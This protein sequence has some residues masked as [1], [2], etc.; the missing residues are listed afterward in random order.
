[1]YRVM[2]VDDELEIRSGLKL[3][4]DWSALGYAIEGEAQ[5]GREALALLEREPFDLVLTDIRMPVMS[6]LELLKQC[7]EN[8]P[9]TKVIVLSGY[10]DFHFVKAALQCGAK[11]YLLKPVV[12]SE[13]TAILGK[14]SGELETER[15][16][17]FSDE[18]ARQR[19]TESESVLKEQLVLDWI[20]NESD[21]RLIALRS[22][23]KRLGMADWL[24]DRSCLQV[25]SLEYRVPEGRLG[26]RVNAESSGLFRLAFQLLCR[27]TLQQRE[28]G[29]SALV[30]YHR[31]YARMMHIVV[32]SP[33]P[34]EGERRAAA[35]CEQLQA[36]VRG[37]LKVE[38]V[39]GVGM[40]FQGPAG[41][42]Q[43][44]LSALMAW[45]RSQSG[46]VSQVI[47]PE[48]G[49]EAGAESF[50]ELE[51]RLELALENLD[52]ESFSAAVESVVQADS[53]PT[54][55]VAAF[56]LRVILLLD[57]TASKYRLSIPET[58]HWMFPDL[59][60]K[61]RSGASALV[62]LKGLASQII[63]G[64]RRSRLAGGASAVEAVRLTIEQSYMNELSLT[65]L[66][67]RFHLNP[68]YL[69][70]LFKKQ[71]GK[72]F[73]D[74]LTQVR[75]GKAEELL[76]DP[77]MRLA[78]IAELVGFANASYLS[79]V[80]KKHFGVSPNEYRNHPPSPPA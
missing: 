55:S 35:L 17:H 20:D 43:G 32:S 78:D 14:V 69:S 28:W 26:E 44:F 59:M 51:R 45:S 22:E 61:H 36:N 80:F 11:D 42:R 46:I 50:S 66:A 52:S 24:D 48:P 40:P 38:A 54:Q 4:I 33:D 25:I 65:M 53:Y 3:K 23:A 60:D 31:S 63:E 41:L 68:T 79:S 70:E 1:M 15:R 76:R 8:Y 47:P 21:D 2:L 49:Q 30:F 73:S 58:Q 13:L 16:A 29:G 71:T 34:A 27:E 57:Q 18:S 37:Y 5:D 72:T 12:R 10:D 64:M 6:G 39:I 56:V 74:Y 77:Q 67:D 62:Y 7:A 75:I 19:I 9:R